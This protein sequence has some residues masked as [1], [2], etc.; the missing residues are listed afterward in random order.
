MALHFVKNVPPLRFAPAAF[1][2]REK[3]DLIYF[4]RKIFFYVCKTDL[5]QITVGQRPTVSLTK[6]NV[7]RKLLRTKPNSN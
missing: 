1:S 5:N 7:G 4:L 2:G 6:N 3:M